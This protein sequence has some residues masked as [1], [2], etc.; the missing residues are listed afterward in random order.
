MVGMCA[1][2]RRA[3][4][5]RRAGLRG[6]RGQSMT[7]AAMMM[8]F[9]LL[10][11]FGHIHLSMLAATKSMVNYAA[12]AAARS[13]MVG[14]SDFEVKL[15]A[16]EV[17][18]AGARWNTTINYACILTGLCLKG[19]QSKSLRGKTR[20]GY[21]LT[22]RVPF[23]LPVFNNIEAGGLAIRG[24]APISIQPSNSEEEEGDNAE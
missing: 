6:E 12:W 4:G 23:G 13:A 1:G 5:V 16:L 9:L 14:A 20:E 18:D 19:D 11:M 3:G 22:Y 24:F 21:L 2:W 7:E 8:L 15:A 17:L 10:L